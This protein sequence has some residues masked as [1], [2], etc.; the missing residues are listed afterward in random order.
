M[1]SNEARHER[2]HAVKV[3]LENAIID[4]VREYVRNPY[5]F[6]G[7]TG[8][9]HYLYFSAHK[10]AGSLLYSIKE[11]ATLLLQSEQY[12]KLTYRNSGNGDSPGRFDFGVVDEETLPSYGPVAKRATT[13]IA[14]EVGL[15]KKFE[16]AV[17][18]IAAAE[19]AFAVHPADVAK[20]VRECC[21]RGL[22]FGY[23]M[24]FYPPEQSQVAAMVLGRLQDAWNTVNDLR[25][26]SN[27]LT[28]VV[29][30][31]SRHTPGLVSSWP[32]AWKANQAPLHEFNDVT[33]VDRQR[34]SPG[35]RQ[36]A[37]LAHC[38]P[39]NLELQEQLRVTMRRL[40]LTP[41]Y[42]KRNMSFPWRCRIKVSN[43]Q[44]PPERIYDISPAVTKALEK[45]GINL[46]GGQLAISED[47]PGDGALVRQVVEPWKK[48]SR[49]EAQTAALPEIK[50]G[51]RTAIW[52]WDCRFDVIMLRQRAR[53]EKTASERGQRGHSLRQAKLGKGG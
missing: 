38:G 41:N 39:C 35:S 52:I 46:T 9:S 28:L 26:V 10:R 48:R 45:R 36:E 5:Q 43:R 12:T 34:V 15:G 3:H 33:D 51:S 27:V 31:G 24:E 44:D 32:S 13:V 40:G 16:N 25:N 1:H 19:T 47:S 22:Q 21:F 18:D 6:H 37:Y 29:L 23:V 49:R 53:V 42:G 50:A 30:G 11:P 17:G 7:D 14:L 20:V 4:T 8:I 2:F